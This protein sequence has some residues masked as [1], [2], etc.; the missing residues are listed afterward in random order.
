MEEGGRLE[1]PS[2][3]RGNGRLVERA[4]R[5]WPG[6]RREREDEGLSGHERAFPRPPR[7]RRASVPV[8]SPCHP[9]QVIGRPLRRPPRSLV[10]RRERRRPS[11]SLPGEWFLLSYGPAPSRRSPPR[12]TR[13]SLYLFRFLSGISSP[14]L[15]P[16]SP[17]LRSARSPFPLVPLAP[18]R[19]PHRFKRGA[20]PSAVLS[21]RHVLSP[22]ASPA[23]NIHFH[24]LSRAA[25]R[26]AA[27]RFTVRL[28]GGV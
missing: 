20:V 4:R 13:P 10:P 1:K 12:R 17:S 7:M 27:R 3:G 5:K 6:Q 21:L 15:L 11:S 16:L 28:G 18:S 22:Y 14:S 26:G 19:H 25:R 24:H 9:T 23:H 8:A 2:N